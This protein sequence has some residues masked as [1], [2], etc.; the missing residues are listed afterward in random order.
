M[1]EL[2]LFVSIVHH[3]SFIMLRNHIQ[4]LGSWNFPSITISTSNDD[5]VENSDPGIFVGGESTCSL[6]GLNVHDEN[7]PRPNKNNLRRTSDGSDGLPIT[8]PLVDEKENR[9]KAVEGTTGSISGSHFQQHPPSP[10]RTT[11]NRTS[12]SY[13]TQSPLSTTPSAATNNNAQYFASLVQ[14]PKNNLYSAPSFERH[15]HITDSSTTAVSAAS[16]SLPRRGTTGSVLSHELNSPRR[17][18]DTTLSNSCFH[19]SNGDTKATTMLPNPSTTDSSSTVTEGIS[20]SFSGCDSDH[21]EINTSKK[22]SLTESTVS[23]GDEANVATTNRNHT[24]PPAFQNESDN[25]QIVNDENAKPESLPSI[26]ISDESSEVTLITPTVDLAEKY[27][28]AYEV[29]A[30]HGLMT[31]RDSIVPPTSVTESRLLS[32]SVVNLKNRES[33]Q[34]N[35]KTTVSDPT[36]SYAYNTKRPEVKN[37]RPWENDR[38]SSF[39]HVLNKWKSKTDDQP[40]DSPGS[41]TI[42]QRASLQPSTN[43]SQQPRTLYSMNNRDLT[44]NVKT[45]KTEVVKPKMKPSSDQSSSNSKQNIRHPSASIPIK[46]LNDDSLPEGSSSPIPKSQASKLKLTSDLSLHNFKDQHMHRQKFSPA[47]THPAKEARIDECKSS[48][49]GSSTKRESYGCSESTTRGLTI[50]R[51]DEGIS[52]DVPRSVKVPTLSNGAS[53]EDVVNKMH[54]SKSHPQIYHS[55][56]YQDHLYM[57]RVGSTVDTKNSMRVIDLSISSNK[58]DCDSASASL[59][60][61][62]LVLSPYTQRVMRNLAKIYN[63]SDNINT[64]RLSETTIHPWQHDRLIHRVGSISEDSNREECCRCSCSNSVFSGSDDLIEFFLPLMGTACV[65]GKAKSG[66]KDPDQ[67]TSLVNILRPW[68]VDFLSRFGIY[69]G[70]E[71]VKSFHR[72]GLAL[73]NAILKYRKNEGMTPYP[74]KSCLMA[75]QIWSKTSKTFVRSIRDQL[76][77]HNRCS[78]VKSNRNKTELKLPNT[79]YILSSFM[80]KVH[81]DDDDNKSNTVIR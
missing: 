20:V 76:S 27:K 56:Q 35:T 40:F 65:C 5:N 60:D 72:S 46:V 48:T 16:L 24:E 50:S 61:D 25:V 73:A 18:I 53:I 10:F 33:R 43:Q 12:G 54:P 44:S 77:V 42:L 70:E 37:N 63:E 47:L 3:S 21:Q 36:N 64:P 15:N 23:R 55:A 7:S 79:L 31:K 62:S 1:F 49:V 68:Q 2:P 4:R 19:T 52:T 69:C 13:R 29:W 74:L 45:T 57:Q 28:W 8:S 11:T 34:Q 38:V 32:S 30:K 9:T 51:T 78:E 14:S 58:D 17:Y 71:L 22:A 41:C 26:D 6:D 59:E 66:M 81:D 39:S 67:P 75:L 80:D